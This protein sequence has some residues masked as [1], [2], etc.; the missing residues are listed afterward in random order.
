MSVIEEGEETGQT[1]EIKEEE[2]PIQEEEQEPKPEPGKQVIE[3][4][5]TI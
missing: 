3:R 4:Q 2:E 1:T 5:I